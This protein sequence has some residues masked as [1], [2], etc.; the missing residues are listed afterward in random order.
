MM[1]LTTL[2]RPKDHK[3]S[4]DHHSYVSLILFQTNGRWLVL[5]LTVTV[6]ISRDGVLEAVLTPSL[7]ISALCGVYYGNFH[8]RNT[9]HIDAAMVGL[10]SDVTLL[11]TNYIFF[12]DD[13]CN[14]IEFFL[15]FWLQ[16]IA[17]NYDVL[18]P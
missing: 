6:H 14:L 9:L 5:V 2:K 11:R 3:V 13:I 10:P 8:S 12:V 4:C 16:F 15:Q 1:A 7:H 17:N 18:K